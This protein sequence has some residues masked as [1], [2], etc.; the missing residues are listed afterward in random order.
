MG[1]AEVFERVG[2]GKLI[3]NFDEPRGVFQRLQDDVDLT[4]P[5]SVRRALRKE[6]GAAVVHKRLLDYISS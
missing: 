2:L 3:V 5:D 6:A 4:I 1:V